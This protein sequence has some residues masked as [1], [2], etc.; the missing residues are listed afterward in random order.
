MKRRLTHFFGLIGIFSAMFVLGLI[1]IFIPSI[2]I[3]LFWN[4]VIC[5]L[6]DASEMNWTIAILSSLLEQKLGVKKNKNG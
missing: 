5:N 6:T 2:P 1:V 3:K 4:Q